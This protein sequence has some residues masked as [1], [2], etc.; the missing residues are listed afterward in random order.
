MDSNL[1]GAL[2]A[3]VPLARR[4]W[5][6]RSREDRLARLGEAS[7][8]LTEKGDELLF[9]GP[10]CRPAFAALVDALAILS[11]DYEVSFGSLTWSPSAPDLGG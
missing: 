10:A 7:K 1:L 8:L 9:G 6:G 5:K 4:T 11:L 3:A 2:A